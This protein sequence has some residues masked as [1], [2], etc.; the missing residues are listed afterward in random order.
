[1]TLRVHKK[2]YIKNWIIFEIDKFPI[3]EVMVTSMIN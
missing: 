1:M 2:R 3:E